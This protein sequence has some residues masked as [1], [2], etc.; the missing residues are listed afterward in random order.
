MKRVFSCCK[1]DIGTNLL[2][3]WCRNFI[4]SNTITNVHLNIPSHH[5]YQ[6]C[7]WV[8]STHKT[9]PNPL[10]I[11]KMWVGLGNWVSMILKIK[12]P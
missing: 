8:R 4:K 1:F 7:T 11:P 2:K 3:L 12:N 10:K 6:G 9:Q 5:N